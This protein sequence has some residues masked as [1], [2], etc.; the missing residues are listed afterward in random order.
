MEEVK[1]LLGNVISL[2]L[3]FALMYFLV[4]RPQQK[5]QKDKQTMIQALKKGDAVVTI[6]GLHG[7]VDEVNQGQGTVVLDC[8]GIYLT[9][10]LGAVA[11]AKE[12][13]KKDP[14]EEKIE[15]TSVTE[16]ATV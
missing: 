4:I 3:I 1:N 10:E 2:V 14:T 12:P 15:E 9:F 7:I 16:D 5:A 11:Q 13:I 8:E 6:G